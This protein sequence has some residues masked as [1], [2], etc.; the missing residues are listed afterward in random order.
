MI[1]R[2]SRP[3]FAALWSDRSRYELWLEVELAACRAM[4]AEA[5]VPAGT[6]EKVQA[7][8]AGVLDPARI[9]EIEERTRHDVIAFLTHVEEVAGEPARWLHLGMTSSD[10]LDT[11]LALQTSR[12]LDRILREL[13]ELGAALRER[14]FEHRDTPCIGRSHGIHAEP[15]TAGLVFTRWYAE[16]SRAAERIHRARSAI[17]VGKIAG[18]VGTYANLSPAIEAAALAALGLSPEP[19]ASQVVARDR[20][21]EVMTAIALAGTAIEQIALGVRHWQRTEV[22]EAEE[23]FA[24]GQKGSSAMPHKKNPILSEN[25]CG[26]ARLLRGYAVAS[27]ESVALWH[28]RDISHSSVERVVMPD[29]TILLDFMLARA[30]GLVKNLVI[31]PERMA[32]NLARSGGLV[33]SEA[34]MLALVRSGLPRQAA[35]ELVQKA[36]LA[37]LAGGGEFRALLGGDPAIAERLTPLEL[38]AAFDLEHH[39]R[40]VGAIY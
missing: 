10:V 24:A 6:A 40:H 21:A 15:I 17:R 27:L 2:Y 37:S 28:E 33:F 9:L 18:A 3:E 22:G 16:V 34:V 19:A 25:L 31:R 1:Q 4:E 11:A 36:A 5:L 12:A 26:L 7:K 20:H 32:D 23:G 38:D 8:A 39:L 29:A 14:A 13:G 35:Y 30:T